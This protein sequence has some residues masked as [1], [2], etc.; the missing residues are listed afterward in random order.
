[1]S[2]INALTFSNALRHAFMAG[3]GV[4]ENG[5]ISKADNEAW[6]ETNRCI[7]LFHD[8]INKILTD[9]IQNLRDAPHGWIG[10]CT[11]TDE[12][13]WRAEKIE[14]EHELIEDVRPATKAEKALLEKTD[15]E[16]I[17]DQVNILRQYREQLAHGFVEKLVEATTK[18]FVAK[19]ID[20]L[21]R[22]TLQI[23]V[24][25]YKKS[26]GASDWYVMIKLE[27]REL[28]LIK[29]PEK[30]QAEYHAAEL[31]WLIKGE[32]KPDILAFNP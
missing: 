27:D 32:A 16:S 23:Y 20:Q 9:H 31:R 14:D 17:Y 15:G 24:G 19:M 28:S 7:D 25:E 29:L 1:M 5:K 4:P 21:Q 30:Y 13:F 2:N 10:Y 3:R 22:E 12:W 8:R 6:V 11:A 26:E 18:Q